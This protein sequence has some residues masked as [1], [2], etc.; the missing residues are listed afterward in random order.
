[1]NGIL[2]AIIVVVV[3]AIIVI[4]YTVFSGRQSAI[5][6]TTVQNQQQNTSTS[7]SSIYTST[8]TGN[9]TNST[10][11]SNSE[12]KTITMTQVI[13]TLGTG[14]T[15]AAQYSYGTSNI[16]LP[17]GPQRHVLGYGIANFSKG[18]TFLST[19]WI[20][21]ANGSSAI[22]YINST[23]N[24]PYP[25]SERQMGSSGNATYVL[26]SGDSINNGQAALTLGAYYKNYA[27]LIINNGSTFPKA[28]AEQLLNYQVTDLNVT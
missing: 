26:Y 10:M 28:Q 4:G 19:E 21:F 14:W 24:P 25:I 12:N 15:A 22:N 6:T 7:A 2:A 3:I 18:G 20:R 13:S 23:F 17:Y 11:P 9:S 5:S 8:I 1:M 27:I 16:T